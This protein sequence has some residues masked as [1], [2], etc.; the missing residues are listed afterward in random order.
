M[1]KRAL[2]LL[3]LT[4]CGGAS[5]L[6]LVDELRVLGLAVEPAS[7]A[8]DEAPQIDVLVADPGGE[9]FQTHTWACVGEVC[10]IC[11]GGTCAGIGAGER[12]DVWALVCAPGAC[13]GPGA[14]LADPDAWMSELPLV[15]VSLARRSAP[16]SPSA[17]ERINA[18][19]QIAW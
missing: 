6:T 3:I 5:P 16:I 19:P 4:G 15:G 8:P 14:D 10:A 13:D 9:G 12:L 11:E 17:T 2:A 18:N 7:P 1:V